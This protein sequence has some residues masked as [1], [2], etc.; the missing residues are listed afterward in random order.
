MVPFPSKPSREGGGR[1][2]NICA[3]R[4]ENVKPLNH[5]QEK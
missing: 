5:G 2:I 3:V 1:Y 4:N